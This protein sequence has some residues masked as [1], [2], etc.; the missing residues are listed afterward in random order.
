MSNMDNAKRLAVGALSRRAAL[1]TPLALAGCETID[2]WF[3]T[4]KDPLPGKREALGVLRRGFNPDE[5]AAKVTVPPAVRNTVWPQ[6]GGN[7]THVMGNLNLSP[8]WKQAW[9]ADL[10]EG[11]GY[12]RKILA[13]PVVAGGVVFAMDSNAVISAFDLNAGKRLWRTA[14]V[15]DD[16]ESSNVGGGLC[17]DNGTLFA[18][19]GMSELLALDPVNGKV[20]WRHDLGVNARS[21]PTVADGRIFLSTLDARLLALSVDDGRQLWVYQAAQAATTYLGDPAPAYAQGIVVA[22]FGSGE[23]AALRVESGSVL[24]TDT[25]GIPR[26]KASLLD[27]LAIR[28]DPVII[29]GQ[30]FVTGMGGLSVAA[31]LLTG[32]RV[33]ERRV[34]SGNTLYAAGNWLFMISTDQEA[35]AINTED[36]RIAWVAALPRWEN[37]EKKK[38]VIT[39][40]G[41][42]L[43]GDRLIILGT[44]KDALSLNPVTGEILG[45]QTLSDVP[46]PFSPVVADG[47]LLVVTE[48]GKLTAYR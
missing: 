26:G 16:I 13:Q 44:N 2:N 8:T 23:V 3:T 21:A 18:T 6:E 38:D 25:L 32:R 42:V 34:A 24:W 22:G 43:A 1:L 15:S 29:N 40:Y 10:G 30:V 9:T 4:K 36:A 19:N 31:D 28:G 48:D 46:S 33:W 20:R 41:P 17:W 5:T 37:E 35:G 12:R 47:T 27:F 45:K 7:P 14:T 39:W 11:G